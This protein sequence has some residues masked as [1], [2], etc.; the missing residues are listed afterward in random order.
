MCLEACSVVVVVV[1]V[2]DCGMGVAVTVIVKKKKR[3]EKRVRA[4]GRE[5]ANERT[6]ERTGSREQA[7]TSEVMSVS[8]VSEICNLI[9]K[10]GMCKRNKSVSGAGVGGWRVEE[11]WRVVVGD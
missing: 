10:S 7:Q 3:E 8:V 2:V 11:G 5:R 4:S 1:G 9:K 6:S